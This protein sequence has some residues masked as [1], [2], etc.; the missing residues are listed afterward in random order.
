LTD[1]DIV[2]QTT[3]KHMFENRVKVI[4]NMNAKPSNNVSKINASMHTSCLK[5]NPNWEKKKKE[6]VNILSLEHLF[7]NTRWFYNN[8][9]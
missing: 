9:S 1:T 8:L 7:F 5:T 3:Q 6:N 2:S 4:Y